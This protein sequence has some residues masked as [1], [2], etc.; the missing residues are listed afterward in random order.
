MKANGINQAPPS[1][2][3]APTAS[4]PRKKKTT[5]DPPPATSPV[6]KRKLA[7]SEEMV[8]DPVRTKREDKKPKMEKGAS[9][10]SDPEFL[11]DMNG[12]DNYP[13]YDEATSQQ[14]DDTAD[15][16]ECFREPDFEHTY[17]G[18][19][20]T[21][22]PDTKYS[23]LKIDD[24]ASSM[25]PNPPG[26]SMS[27]YPHLEIKGENTYV[28]PWDLDLSRKYAGLGDTTAKREAPYVSPYA[29]A[30]ADMLMPADESASAHS[31][32]FDLE[33]CTSGYV[34]SKSSVCSKK[35]RPKEEVK[36]EKE[37]GS[38]LIAD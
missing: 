33:N 22:D 36:K 20:Q 13:W 14:R 28:N 21:Q 5:P 37:M 24:Q 9:A 6:K 18:L 26:L 12:P 16:A 17:G 38:I 2:R 34:E 27:K 25:D 3:D 31:T 32:A 7:K 23:V 8:N 11:N 10:K 15:L 35:V 1:I 29:P 19:S 4:R 30:E